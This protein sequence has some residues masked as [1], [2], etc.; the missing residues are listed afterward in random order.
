VVAF[1]EEMGLLPTIVAKSL[2]TNKI[3]AALEPK[4]PCQGEVFRLGSS[5]QSEEKSQHAAIIVIR[6]ADPGSTILPS[7]E[8]LR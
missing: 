5:R 4:C 8:Q 6:K 1:H 3:S 7:R 2:F